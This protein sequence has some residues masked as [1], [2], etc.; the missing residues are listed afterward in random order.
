[1]TKPILVLSTT[2]PY[3][4]KVRMLAL[5][6]KMEFDVKVD[7]PW[8]EDT[9]VV[10][11]NPLGK[12]PVWMTSNQE[13][14]Y[15]SRVITEFLEISNGF[16]FSSSDPHEYI[17]IKRLEALAEGV[18]DA[19]LCLFAER[20]KRPVELQHPWWVERQFAKIH[21]GLSELS[22]ILGEN[23]F[24][25]GNRLTVADFGLIAALGYVELRFREDFSIAEKY[26]TLGK[27]YDKMMEKDSV[28][29]TIPV[30]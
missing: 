26:P 14:I 20:R 4:R 30:L 10:A 6:N 18:M 17:K 11:L 24:L 9:G 27:Y 29:Q 16:K 8:N 5:E 2:S 22:K 13:A 15:D 1:M 21:R 23:R 7:V 25:F 19:S 12:V 3:A 28:R